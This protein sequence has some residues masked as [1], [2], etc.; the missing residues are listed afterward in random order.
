MAGAGV[1]C[2]AASGCIDI[3]GADTAKYVERDEKHFTVSGK[4]AVSLSTFDGAIEVRTWD[5]SEVLVTIEKRAVSKES[6]A[7]IEVESQQDGDHV[8]VDVKIPRKE[9]F[10]IHFGDRRSAKLIVSVPA[11]SDMSARSGDGS[12]DV[13]GVEGRVDLGSGD[14]SIQGRRLG[15]EVKAHTGD[16]SVRFDG[17]RGALDVDTGD[18]SVVASGTFSSVRARSGDGSVTI[19]AQ[20]GST[21]S[22]EWN[23]TTGDGAV[24]LALPDGFGGE[25]DAHTGDGAIHMSDMEV[26]NVTGEIRK[27]TVR[28]RLGAGGNTVRV[29]TGDG[30][31]TLKRS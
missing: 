25:L 11:A 28:G 30:S 3:V 8:R 24:T 1:M 18:G 21:S 6:A 19:T 10:G 20:S 23:I 12:I 22:S 7:T 29:R 17:V 5:R 31:I 9:R 13:E 2:L 14:G 26:S 4:P 15:G 16:G 27:N